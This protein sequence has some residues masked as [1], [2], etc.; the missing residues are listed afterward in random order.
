M[1]NEAAI[2]ALYNEGIPIKLPTRFTGSA[3]IKLIDKALRVLE[4]S[5]KALAD[6]E[7]VIVYRVL[8]SSGYGAEKF[9][10]VYAESIARG[11]VKTDN[12]YA[13]PIT[14]NWLKE[15]KEK[16]LSGKYRVI[17]GGIWGYSK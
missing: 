4:K 17:G 14:Y 3:D 2:M 16:L 6:E 10:R 11:I 5:S 15:R 7:A 1:N 8:F 9:H 12:R 13:R